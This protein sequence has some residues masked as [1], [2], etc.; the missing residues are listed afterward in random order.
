MV[1]SLHMELWEVTVI[2]GPGIWQILTHHTLA[3]LKHCCLFLHGD[4]E[5]EDGELS[6]GTWQLVL[7][8]GD[9]RRYCSWQGGHEG[10]SEGSW[11][12]CGWEEGAWNRSEVEKCPNSD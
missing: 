9:G 8:E 3:F 1:L 11:G 4:Q 2:S 6:V 10:G 7:K 5:L 12:R